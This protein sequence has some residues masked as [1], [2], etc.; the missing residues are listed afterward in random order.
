MDRNIMLQLSLKAEHPAP[1]K[2]SASTMERQ[3]NQTIISK[4]PRTALPYNYHVQVFHPALGQLQ[5]IVVALQ[6]YTTLTRLKSQ[7]LTLLIVLPVL[8]IVVPLL[9]YGFSALVARQA[10]E[11]FRQ[12]EMDLLGV[13]FDAEKVVFHPV[14]GE[15]EITNLVMHNPEG[16]E[17]PYLMRIGHIFINL[18]TYVYTC[19]G[20]KRVQIDQL[21]F[22]HVMIFVEKRIGGSNLEFVLSHIQDKMKDRP[23]SNVS[24]SMKEGLRHNL[25]SCFGG[26]DYEHLDVADLREV[27]VHRVHMKF[28]TRVGGNQIFHF[29]LQV[30]KLEY[31]NFSEEEKA[32]TT[33]EII[34]ILMR[35]ILHS[36]SRQVSVAQIPLA[37][38]RGAKQACC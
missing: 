28:V 3:H 33:Q 2:V 21:H 12:F 9:Y 11:S 31:S 38:G 19:S 22:D 32:R 7:S 4:D 35:T 30:P 14:S 15:L 10:R 34:L 36:A 8:L 20:F 37:W 18:N 27:K 13:E 23:Q 26:S 5:R 16:F 25:S 24:F 1:R 17:Y 29:R 6:A